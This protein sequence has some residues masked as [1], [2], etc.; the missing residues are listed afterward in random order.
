MKVINILLFIFCF[1]PISVSAATIDWRG[2]ILTYNKKDYWY[3]NPLNSKRYYF[4]DS[5][6]VKRLLKKIAT[7]VPMTNFQQ[8][9]QLEMPVAGNVE[10][11]KTYSGRLFYEGE[12]GKNLWYINPQKL[13]R[14]SIDSANLFKE[15]KKLATTTSAAI[16]TDLPK[17]SRMKVL[18]NF[19]SYERKKIKTNLGDFVTD[20]IT[21]DLANPNLKI[22]T[23]ATDNFNCKKNCQ[24][25]TLRSYIEEHE[26][27]AAMNGT[28][29]DTGASKLNYYFFPV[30]NSQTGKFIN[31]DQLKYWTTGPIMAFDQNNKFYYFKDSREFKSVANFE[32]KYGVKLQAAIG[33]K[34]RLIEEGLNYLI[35]WEVDVKQRTVKTLRNALA[36]KNGK[37]Y[38]IVT[39]KSTV[40]DLAEVLTTLGMEYGLNLDGGYSTALFYD[41]V[42]V[43][44]PGRNI[45]NAILFSYKNFSTSTLIKK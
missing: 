37:L 28:Y 12:D 38:L 41:E 17:N 16:L 35:D 39:Q 8:I 22:I 44:G 31:E 21:I 9:A 23:A 14:Q 32:K 27:F 13:K 4:A 36:Y 15:M 33:N 26:A 45:P 42:M 34:P 5:A 20:I 24:A 19:S 29:F 10:L 11:A 6:D 18:D 1:L 2:Q 3:V 25:R 40:P 7:S 30:F 43:K